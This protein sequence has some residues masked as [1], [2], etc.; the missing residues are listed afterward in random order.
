MGDFKFDR[1]AI[2]YDTGFE[3]RLSQKFYHLIYNT[4]ELKPSDNVLDVGCGTGTLLKTLSEI[5]DING[6]GIDIEP[7]ML[8]IAKS[9]CPDMDIRKNS[10]DNTDYKDGYFDVLTTCMAYHHFPSKQGFEKEAERILKPG[11]YLYIADPNF[12]FLIRKTINILTKRFNG[13]FLSSDEIKKR[14]ENYGFSYIG[15]KT[16]YYAQLV[17]FKKKIV[18]II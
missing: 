6:H 9:K 14:F 10:C 16:D 1:R 18:K 11:G 4:I 8:N 15:T 5:E 17:I 7:N 3:G 13:E 2:K 12:P